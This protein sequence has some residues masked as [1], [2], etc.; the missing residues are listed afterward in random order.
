MCFVFVFGTAFVPIYTYLQCELVYVVLNILG[1]YIAFIS[2][3]QNSLSRCARENEFFIHYYLYILRSY[4]VS[5][6]HR[7]D[8]SNYFE[9]K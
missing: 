3:I 6:S 9:I 7:R 8:Q 5:R 2:Q 4:C 1:T